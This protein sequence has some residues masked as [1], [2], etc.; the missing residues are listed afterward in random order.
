[1]LTPSDF[2]DLAAYRQWVAMRHLLDTYPERWIFET[3]RRNLP[4]VGRQV[5]GEYNMRLVHEWRRLLD[6][7]DIAILRSH[8]LPATP[9]ACDMRQI[10]PLHGVMTHAEW[11][12]IIRETRNEWNRSTARR[13]VGH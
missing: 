4:K 12:N 9:R 6:D 7:G 11:L 1:M 3:G 2:P 8:V 5:Q 13:H 10:S